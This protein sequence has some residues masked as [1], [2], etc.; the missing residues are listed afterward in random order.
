MSV[1][2]RGRAE[3]PIACFGGAGARFEDENGPAFIDFDDYPLPPLLGRVEESIAGTQHDALASHLER[4]ESENRVLF[5]FAP[6]V[7]ETSCQVSDA[8]DRKT[9]S[10]LVASENDLQTRCLIGARKTLVDWGFE[11]LLTDC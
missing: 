7:L 10:N 4:F 5:G 11:A 9:D 2:L 3:E 1:T 8:V 6:A